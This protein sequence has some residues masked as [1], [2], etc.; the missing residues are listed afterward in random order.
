MKSEH[1]HKWLSWIAGL[2]VLGGLTLP[3]LLL[4]TS[5]LDRWLPLQGDDARLALALF[6]PTV[7]SWGA[8]MFF[9]V[10]YGLRNRQRW[11]ADALI[12][13]IL[14]WA[15]LDAALCWKYQLSAGLWLDAIAAPAILIPALWCRMQMR[16]TSR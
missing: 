1:L 3:F 4:R 15:P 13:G 16:A 7:A 10:Q 11:A 6:G 12:V 9:L 8:M 2:H 5:W 14:V